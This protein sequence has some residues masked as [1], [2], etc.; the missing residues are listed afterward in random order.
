MQI[1]ITEKDLKT[2]TELAYIGNW[3]VNS[4]RTGKERI[5]KYDRVFKKMAKAYKATLSKEEKEDF[6][7]PD[8]FMYELGDFI[9]FYEDNICIPVFTQMLAEFNYPD[10]AADAAL[11]LYNFTKQEQAQQL[12]EIEINERGLG[13][14]RI[15]VPD[16]DE[17]LAA[18][19]EIARLCFGESDVPKEERMSKA[20]AIARAL[21][22][23]YG[24]DKDKDPAK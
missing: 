11:S 8:Y 2:L 6:E 23:K 17:R 19:Q 13:A 9:E 21:R 10:H 3:I 4:V 1:E 14:V 15:D 12:Y 20:E 16:I 5:L 7:V 18:G 22:D 24:R